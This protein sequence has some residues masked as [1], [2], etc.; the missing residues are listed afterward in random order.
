MVKWPCWGGGWNF[1]TS[2]Q[3]CL[4]SE[5][6]FQP[7]AS[8]HFIFI[9]GMV[10]WRGWDQRSSV[11]APLPHPNRAWSPPITAEADDKYAGCRLLKSGVWISISFRVSRQCSIWNARIMH[12]KTIGVTQS[13]RFV[14][15]P[16][17]PYIFLLTWQLL[18]LFQPL[19]MV[20]TVIV[21][22]SGIQNKVQNSHLWLRG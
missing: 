14:G 18:F 13:N 20:G 17:T 11:R 2:W 6:L 5:F 21:S 4:Q 19:N 7:S 15:R 1:Y 12:F 3:S 8:L 22:D 9:L 16:K 10:P